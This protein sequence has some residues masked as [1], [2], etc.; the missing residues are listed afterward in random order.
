MIA[1]YQTK[2]IRFFLT[3]ASYCFTGKHNQAG[4]RQGWG[5][6]HFCEEGSHLENIAQVPGQAEARLKAMQGISSPEPGLFD[7]DDD[8]QG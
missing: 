8:A 6:K 3:A 7:L 2:S 1:L 5:W 4:W